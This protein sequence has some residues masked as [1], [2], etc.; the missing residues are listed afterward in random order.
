M[1]PGDRRNSTLDIIQGEKKQEDDKFSRQSGGDGGGG[2]GGRLR[3][4]P[5]PP[6]G[7]NSTGRTSR[8]F[9]SSKRSSSGDGPPEAQDSS[10]ESLILITVSLTFS[11][12]NLFVQH[13]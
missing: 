4:H 11:N 7:I 6:G 8:D 12:L 13:I 1:G 10:S 9:S 3:N 5:C 2:M